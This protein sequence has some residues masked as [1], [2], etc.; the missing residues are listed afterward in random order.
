MRQMPYT[1]NR[2]LQS[3][4][5]NPES[6]IRILII[7]GLLILSAVQALQTP[8]PG[9]RNAFLL[10]SL[11]PTGL[12]VLSIWRWPPMG[13]L[14]LI[15]A[16][17]IIPFSIGTGTGTTLNPVILL[18]PLLTSLWLLN[19]LL[20][21]KAIS[22]HHHRAVYLMLG[23]CAVATIAFIVGQLPW[24]NLK[25][26]GIASQLGGLSVFLLSAAAFLLAAHLLDERWLARLVWVFLAIGTLYIVSRLLPSPFNVAAQLFVR[27]TTGSVFWIWL[28]ALSAGLA[29]FHQSLTLRWRLLTA[30]IAFATLFVGMAQGLFWA[31]GW[32][33][34]LVGLVIVFWLRYPKWG[35]LLV[36]VLV[37]LF[38]SEQVHIFATA[39]S[40]QSWWARRQAWQI[41]L[42]TARI[43]PLLGLG[44]ANYYFYV[45]QA[46]IAGWGGV[47]NVR[48]SSHNNYVD[49]IAQTGLLGLALF[50]WLAFTMGRL[51]WTLYKRLHNGFAR[52]YAA[53]CLGGLAATLISGVLG[54][55]FLPFVYN[56]GLNGMRSSILY[57]VF[58]GGLL[59]LGIRQAT[60]MKE[61]T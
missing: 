59:T 17:L 1:A 32:A 7:T 38:L 30:G 49:L 31:S 52:A 61:S 36:L 55:W 12:F 50:L 57:W 44:P 46:D 60:A 6:T 42:D 51:G 22:L 10:L 47:W 21:K 15:V 41:V 24:F 26:A 53:A 39:T 40:D 16:G 28:V 48:F 25:G 18:I 34:P 45:Q 8:V 2:F 14:A 33:P 54:D 43:N 35:L 20:I 27:G 13:L 29:L 4:R 56:I 5:L 37:A 19:M 11:V 58:L 3:T 23:F 9:G